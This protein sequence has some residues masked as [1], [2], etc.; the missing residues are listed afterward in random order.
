MRRTDVIFG[1][2]SLL[3]RGHDEP[4]RAVNISMLVGIE[5]KYCNWFITSRDEDKFLT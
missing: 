5:K 4:L 2:D 1:N 3:M